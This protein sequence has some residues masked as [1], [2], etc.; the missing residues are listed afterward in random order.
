MVKKPQIVIAALTIILFAFC[1]QNQENPGLVNL[2][3]DN[4]VTPKKMTEVGATTSTPNS[5]PDSDIEIYSIS[6]QDTFLN[7]HFQNN[8]PLMSIIRCRMSKANSDTFIN[9][10]MSTLGVREDSARETKQDSLRFRTFTSKD[11]LVHVSVMDSMTVVK[12][13]LLHGESRKVSEPCVEGK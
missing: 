5:F 1:N 9:D 3:V 8:Q 11:L 2:F 12:K 6:S 10:L 7:V 13:M 4:S